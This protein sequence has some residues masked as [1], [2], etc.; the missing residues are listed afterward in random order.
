MAAP[1]RW[2]PMPGAPPKARRRMPSARPRAAKVLVPP[3]VRA[4]KFSSVIGAIKDADLKGMA[5]PPQSES[6]APYRARDLHN[7][8]P[9]AVRGGYRFALGDPNSDE[10]KWIRGADGNPFLLSLA[11][12][13]G[14][15]RQRV[16]DAFIGGR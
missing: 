6:G 3:D 14:T 9:V 8:V 13:K 7:A 2:R 1:S 5:V 16:P 10:P 4:D 15:L 11:A 12:L